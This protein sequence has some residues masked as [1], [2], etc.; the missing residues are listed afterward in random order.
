[1]PYGDGL[2]E[3]R[4]DEIGEGLRDMA[5]N[6]HVCVKRFHSVRKGRDSIGRHVAF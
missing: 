1:M 4:R 6:D 3:G 5:G 2:S